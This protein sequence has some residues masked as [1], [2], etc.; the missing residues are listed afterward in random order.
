MTWRKVVHLIAAV[1]VL[2][3][4]AL[5]SGADWVDTHFVLYSVSHP[6]K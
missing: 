6:H 5:A 4:L 2:S 1:A 3:S